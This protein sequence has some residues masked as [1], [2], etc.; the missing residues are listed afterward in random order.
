MATP[1][2]SEP[3]EFERLAG[4][5]RKLL[6]EE[7]DTPFKIAVMQSLQTIEL[8]RHK[9]TL[10]A[11]QTLVSCVTCYY[12]GDELSAQILMFVSGVVINDYLSP[13]VWDVLSRLHKPV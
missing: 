6:D 4:D 7:K 1:V 2:K 3:D 13:R 9:N 10:P 11:L 8:V 12:N 5:L